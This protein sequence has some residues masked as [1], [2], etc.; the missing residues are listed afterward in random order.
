MDLA[1]Q[2]GEHTIPMMLITSSENLFFFCRQCPGEGFTRMSLQLT[3]AL[4]LTFF[5]ILP[6]AELAGLDDKRLKEHAQEWTY[7]EG[8]LCECEP[9][10]VRLEL[11]PGKEAL[12]TKMIQEARVM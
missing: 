5:D 9:Y 1:L 12:F 6:P 11:R 7:S 8:T 4:L 10:H 3:L 2:R